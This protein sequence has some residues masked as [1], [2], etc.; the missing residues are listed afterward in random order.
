MEDIL[1]LI[2]GRKNDQ[3][4]RCILP[5]P[6]AWEI[7]NLEKWSTMRQLDICFNNVDTFIETMPYSYDNMADLC[8]INTKNEI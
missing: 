6:S 3:S 2:N 8:W 4:V 5:N 7:S 1:V